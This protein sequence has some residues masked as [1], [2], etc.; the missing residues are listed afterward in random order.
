MKCGGG[1]QSL[2]SS[3]RLIEEDQKRLCSRGISILDL[4][5]AFIVSSPVL[6]NRLLLS[7]RNIAITIREF[8]K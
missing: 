4:D 5:R 7:I 1:W 8:D 2:R 6:W 3:S